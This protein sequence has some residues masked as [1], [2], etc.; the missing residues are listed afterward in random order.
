MKQFVT[1]LDKKSAAFKYLQDFFPKLSELKMK[2]G[3]QVMKIMECSEFLQLTEKE[4][5]K[6][7]WNFSLL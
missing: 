4:C 6:K 2:A 7:N 5:E 3:P 1:P